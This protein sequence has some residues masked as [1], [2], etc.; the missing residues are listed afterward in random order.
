MLERKFEKYIKDYEQHCGKIRQSTQVDI[1]EEPKWKRARMKK[2]EKSYTRWFE[3]YFPMYAKSECAPF[4]KK[5]ANTIIDNPVSSTLAEIY[6]SGAK[7]VHV[8]M[9][10]PLYMYVKG[11]LKYMLLVGETEPKAAQLLSDIQAQ[12]QFNQRFINDYG[13]K[14]QHGSWAEG[15]FT[16]T[17]GVKFKSLGFGQSPRG[18]REGAERPDYIVIDDIDN[19]I[20]CN[21]DKRSREAYE[22]T[23]ED[24]QGCFD[25]GSERRRFVCANNNFHKN[26]VINQLKTEFKR[27][28]KEYQEEDI[29][30]EHFIITVPA[31]KDL[32]TFEPSWPAKTDAE[33]WKKKFRGTPYRSFMREYM[34]KHIQDGTVFKHDQIQTTKIL[35]LHKYDALIVYGDLSYKD[36]GDFKAQI[37]VGKIGNEFHVIDAFVRQS[38]RTNAAKW[39][40][41]LYENR[42]LEKVYAKYM[43]EGLFAMDDFVNDYDL[44]G[45][46]RGYLI[47]VV[48]D[49]K[50][51]ANKFERI[52]SMS[53]YFERG[54]VFFNERLIQ[55]TDF[56]NLIDQLLAF[57]KGSGAHDDAP[58]AL[59]SAISKLNTETFVEKF[60]P[61]IPKRRK[62]GRKRY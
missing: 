39:L 18:V 1:N 22:W 62:S 50:S 9:G 30:I 46:L 36:N 37:L 53:G 24:L 45:E 55:S 11:E 33:Y 20:R 8:D 27:T 15:D 38:S 54:D 59:Q 48:A 47:P 17:D 49:K 16:T 41:D 58:D 13:K 44:E 6:R 5:L 14:F 32:V 19:K 23:W 4:H 51:K 34:H 40:Y 35:P 25:E 57:E 61:R 3:Y 21:N 31:V 42:K 60:K 56:Q 2:L 10:I 28:I 29:P 43:I 12:L 52:E 7:S 26:T